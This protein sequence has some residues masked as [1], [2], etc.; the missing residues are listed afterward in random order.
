MVNKDKR[1]LTVQK[2]MQAG[3]IKYFEDIFLHISRTRVAKD[4]GFNNDRMKNLIFNEVEGW[5][6]RDLYR[7]AQL[8]E[9]EEA[10]MLQLVNE[11]YLRDRKKKKK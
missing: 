5:V 4:I 1:Y 8:F 9:V 3:H 7:L 2:L 11:Q 6:V 10:S